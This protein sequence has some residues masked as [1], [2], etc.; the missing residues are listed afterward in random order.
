MPVDSLQNQVGPQGAWHGFHSPDGQT[1]WLRPQK[2][3]EHPTADIEDP[4][5]L[6]AAQLSGNTKETPK[7]SDANVF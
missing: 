6:A 4:R 7:R 5:T 2:P 1:W 3:A